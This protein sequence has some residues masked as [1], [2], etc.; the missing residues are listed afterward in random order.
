VI[1]LFVG[2]ASPREALKVADVQPKQGVT[3]PK[4]WKKL[5][6][7]NRVTLRLP[8]D[9]K[10]SELIGDS[11]AY[12]EAYR[13]RN[14]EI[15]IAYGAVRPLPRPEQRV[16]LVD[17]CETSKSL[18]EEPTYQES[19]V[20][21]DGRKANLRIDRAYQPKFILANVCFLNPPDRS[22]QLIVLAYCKDEHALETAQQIFNSIKFTEGE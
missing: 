6:I 20:E 17:P 11:F 8:Q 2:N 22:E 1:F 13:N 18:R 15:T 12:R 3:Q 14:I 9:M 10:P 19:V 5:D 16:D 4:G 21:I 7:E